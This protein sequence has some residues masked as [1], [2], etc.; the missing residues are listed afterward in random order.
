MK[1]LV[2]MHQKALF[3]ELVIDSYKPYSQ[4]DTSFTNFWLNKGS[5]DIIHLHW[6]EYL[7]KWEVPTDTEL[8]LLER[9]LTEWSKKG[10][11]IVVTRHNY[12]P[13]RSNPERYTPLYDLVYYHADAVIHM[14]RYSE[15]EYQARYGENINT[16][17]VQAQIPHPIFTNYPNTVSREQARSYLKINGKTKVML[18]F[19]EVRKA[20]EKNLVLQAFS[21]IP[22]KDKLLLVPGWKFSKGK[23]P[24]NKI[25]WLKIN[26]SR[27]HRIFKE[28]IPDEQVQFYFKAADFVFLPRVD[29]LNSGVP[30]LAVA[31]H[32]PIVG[33]DQGNIGEILSKLKMPTFSQGSTQDLFKAIHTALSL[34]R[35]ESLYTSFYNNHCPDVVGKQHVNLFQE[36][37]N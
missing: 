31:F 27:K 11:K 13:H 3:V 8:L 4:V 14:G 25:K 5:Y 18:V 23:E 1:V 22:S 36:L 29:T 28:F 24:I 30:L 10:S 17:Q 12:L 16:S 35:N 9:V 32:T 7:F 6:P 33:V 34:Q 20:I 19:G 21:A 26:K 15:E 37:L 2:P